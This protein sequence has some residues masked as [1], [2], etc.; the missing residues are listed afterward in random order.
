MLQRLRRE[1]A[2]LRTEDL[3]AATRTAARP[4]LVRVAVVFAIPVLVFAI[5][6]PLL[7]A[8]DTQA[9]AD[10]LGT[11]DVSLSGGATHA[12]LTRDEQV[13]R[14]ITCL[15]RRNVV[16][17]GSQFCSHCIAQ[18]RLFAPAAVSVYHECDLVVPQKHKSPDCVRHNIT[19]YPTWIAF[20]SN[21]A[22][23]KTIFRS[24]G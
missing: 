17:Y 18:K 11:V 12:P 23:A 7:V 1:K 9:L 20:A 8:S 19:G 13:S 4:W 15:E 2:H 22:N 6:R 5:A 14:L 21:D 10:A 24:S 3:L 16:M